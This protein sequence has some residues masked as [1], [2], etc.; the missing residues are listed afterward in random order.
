MKAVVCKAY[1]PPESLVLEEVEPPRPGKGQ[2]VISV[3]AAGLNFP[4]TL[5]LAGKY[6]IKPPL[7]FSPGIEVAGVVK[8]IGEGV[9]TVRVGDRVIALVD[10]GGF[11][12][13]VLTEAT[14]LFAMPKEMDF[15]LAS[16]LVVAY[17]TSY[18]ALKDRGHLQ[19]G[20]TLLVLG[21]GGGVGL[22]AIEL[23]KVM[24]ARVIAAASTEEK[25]ALCKQQ[26]ADELI[27]YATQDLRERVKELTNGNGVDVIYDPVGGNYSE[28]ALRSMAWG[29]RFLVIGFTTGDI[30]RIPLNLVLLKSCSIVG[31]FF[32]ASLTIHEPALHQE[33][34]RQLCSWWQ[35]GKIKPLIGATYPLH[36]ATDALN[37][38]QK[39]KAKGKLVLVVEEG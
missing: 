35:A 3:R 33:H 23:G 2:V 21:A 27:N 15:P 10:Y 5:F 26:G 36:R 19:P 11:A 37:D 38:M 34:V 14:Q 6:Q 25:L 20:E 39:R 18:Y 32:W 22:S 8:E 7:P 17:G 24:G 12:E 29:G 31:V 4:D 28:A 30:A 16:A 1:G 9:D 13:M